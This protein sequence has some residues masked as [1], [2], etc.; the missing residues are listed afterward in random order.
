MHSTFA[1]P[2]A[3]LLLGSYMPNAAGSEEDKK[4]CWPDPGRRYRSTS[5]ATKLEPLT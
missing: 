3:I 4:K 1:V 5:Q 2:L